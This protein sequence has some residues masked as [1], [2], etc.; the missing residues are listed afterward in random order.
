[1]LSNISLDEE[2]LNVLPYG[3]LDT[4]ISGMSVVVKDVMANSLLFD[5]L[6]VSKRIASICRAILA[7]SVYDDKAV[8]WLSLSIFSLTF[9]DSFCC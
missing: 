7:S 6:N 5:I 2:L 9:S 4:V 8:L 1:M 3:L